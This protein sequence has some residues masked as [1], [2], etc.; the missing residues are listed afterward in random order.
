MTAYVQPGALFQ[1]GDHVR[2][3][4]STYVVIARRRDHIGI[5][6]QLHATTT[7]LPDHHNVPQGQLKRVRH[8][9]VR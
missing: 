3:A 7:D 4:D 2:Y 8:E 6:Y 5:V 9:R 1:L